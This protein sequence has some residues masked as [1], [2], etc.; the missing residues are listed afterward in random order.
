MKKNI[1]ERERGGSSC[2]HTHTHTPQNGVE[3]AANTHTHTHTG[4]LVDAASLTS[5]PPLGPAPPIFP[6]V[7]PPP[8]LL[9]HT[10]P[11]YLIL[12]EKS[13]NFAGILRDKTMD[14][15][16]MYI[17]PMMQNKINPSVD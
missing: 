14:D 1:K 12:S 2:S 16:L 6:H 3:L 13:H 5:F 4:G 10:R 11:H 17:S 9:P 7:T 8:P 15:T